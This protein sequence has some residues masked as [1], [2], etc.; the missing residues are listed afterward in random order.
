MEEVYEPASR[1]VAYAMA[2]TLLSKWRTGGMVGHLH[3][4]MH[5]LTENRQ[6]VAWRDPA[7]PVIS[8]AWGWGTRSPKQWPQVVGRHTCLSARLRSTHGM[9]CD[10]TTSGRISSWWRHWP[11]KRAWRPAWRWRQRDNEVA[12]EVVTRMHTGCGDPPAPSPAGYICVCVCNCDTSA[13]NTERV[14]ET[15]KCTAVTD[16]QTMKPLA[17]FPRLHSAACDVF[18]CCCITQSP[19]C[20]AL[21]AW[22]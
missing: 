2:V 19:A 22:N 21:P 18:A 11:R 15:V 12:S 16:V 17:W 10:L 20:T 7:E 5:Q 4:L 9:T 1:A 6:H 8:Q 13:E 14:R 3:K